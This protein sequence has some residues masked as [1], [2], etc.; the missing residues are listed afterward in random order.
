MDLLTGKPYSPKVHPM[1]YEVY[2]DAAADY[3]GFCCG[4]EAQLAISDA[5]KG[6]PISY[7][8]LGAIFLLLDRAPV[9]CNL[10]IFTDSYNSLHAIKRGSSTS[11]RMRALLTHIFDLIEKKNLTVV[12]QYVNTKLNKADRPS[13]EKLSAISQH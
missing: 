12:C 2:T 11:E 8:E 7:R 13:R 4:E 10:R 5:D 6:T 3:Y 9:S 1:T